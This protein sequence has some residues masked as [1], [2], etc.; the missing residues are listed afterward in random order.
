M[1]TYKC[2]MCGEVWLSE[3][4]NYCPLCGYGIIVVEE[5]EL[6]QKEDEGD[7]L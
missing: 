5:H 2:H 7:Y 3:E 6:P 1:T 4:Y